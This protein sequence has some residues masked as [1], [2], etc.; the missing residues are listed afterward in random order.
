[1]HH[2]WWEDRNE[3]RDRENR[4]ENVLLQ[5]MDMGRGA[6]WFGGRIKERQKWRGREREREKGGGTEDKFRKRPGWTKTEV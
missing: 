4:E 6:Q 3:D 5:S 2:V 1:M